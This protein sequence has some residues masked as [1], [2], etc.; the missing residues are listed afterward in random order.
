MSEELKGMDA[1]IK[2]LEG[3][4][5]DPQRIR[6]ILFLFLRFVSLPVLVLIRRNFGERSFS[7]FSLFIVALI[8]SFYG[9]IGSFFTQTP[10]S[11]GSLMIFTAAFLIAG[12]YHSFVISR[13]NFR[14]ER[15]HSYYE[16]DVL[17]IFNYFP[18]ANMKATQ[19][20]Y[21]PAMVYGLS[22]V[23][24]HYDEQLLALWL[25]IA[26]TGMVTIAVLNYKMGRNRYLDIID[27]QI[28]A[29]NM[30]AA[31]NG[32]PPKET[33]GFVVQGISNVSSPERAR[34]LREL[35]KVRDLS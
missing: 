29:E 11:G 8:L 22:F 31:L 5:H 34:M 10:S 23:A 15:W 26:A 4:L 25:K 19:T 6:N 2:A 1:P 35:K 7:F 33:D 20:I 14:G 24:G 9:T 16:G 18:S 32:A 13:R 3:V 21:E 27:G 17:P 12:A 28:E 30:Q